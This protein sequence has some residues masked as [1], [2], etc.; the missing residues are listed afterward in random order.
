MA[1]E[2]EAAPESAERGAPVVVS[3]EPTDAELAAIMSAYEALWPKPVTVVERTADSN[4]WRFS[5]RRWL[6]VRPG[7]RR[8]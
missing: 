2:T 1:G 8:R 7:G 6:P 3:P 5:G 4:R